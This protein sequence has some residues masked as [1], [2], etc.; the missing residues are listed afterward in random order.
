MESYEKLGAFYL[1]REYDLGA[2]KIGPGQILY[3]SKDLCTHA[4]LVGMTGSGKT[5]LGISLLEEA[6]IDNIPVIAIDPKGDLTNLLLTF[7]DLSPQDFLPWINPQEA[8]AAGRTQAQYAADQAKIWAKG[9]ADW[10][11]GPERIARLKAAAEMTVYTPGSSA[12]VPVNVLRSFSPPPQAVR[13][14]LDLWR[15]R[16]KTTASSLLALL[17]LES[18]PLTS[19]EHILLSN[20]L[21][22]FWSAGRSLDLAGLIQSIQAPPL[23]RIGVM[24]LDSFFPAQD[25]FALAMRLNGLLAAPGFEAWLE[26]PTLD[27][28]QLLQTKDGRPRASIFTISHLGDAER[29]FFVSMLFNEALGWM[30]SQPGTTS[31]RALI[32]MDEVFGFFPPVKNPPSKEPLL[33]LLKQARA[34]GLGVVLSTQNPVDLDYKGLSNAGTWFVGRLQAE[35]DKERLLAG[36]EG[37]SAGP[38]FDRARLDKIISGLGKRVF[39]M[40][41]VHDDQPRVFHTRWAL[42]YLRGP[43]TREQIKTLKE[44]SGAPVAVQP[45]Q[46]PPPGLPPLGQTPAPGLPATSPALDKAP[47]PAPAA[48]AGPPP[49]SRPVLP[50][51]LRALY[52]PAS[53]AGAD[54][55]YYPAVMGCLEVNYTSTKYGLGLSKPLVLASQLEDGPIPLDWDQV[56]DLAMDPGNLLEEPMS[57]V[58]HA[59]LP[60]LAGQSKAYKQWRTDLLRWVRHNR[61][62]VLLHSKDFDLTSQPEEDEGSF[63]ARLA[64]VAREQ[65]DLSVEKL[66]NKYAT[67]F[68]TLENRLMRAQQAVARESEQAKAKKIETAIS[69]GSAI[70]G[71]F[72]G[73]KAISANSAYRVGTAMKTAGRTRKEMM[74]VGRAKETMEAVQAE[75]AELE[76]RVQEEVAGMEG[77]FDPTRPGVGG[78]PHPGQVHRHRGAALRPGLAALSPGRDRPPDP[79]LGVGAPVR[80]DLNDRNGGGACSRLF[81]W[82][83]GGP[84]ALPCPLLGTDLTGRYRP[85][86][87]RA[88]T[89][90]RAFRRAADRPLYQ[91]ADNGADPTAQNGLLDPGLQV[92]QT[93]D[94][95]W[96]VVLKRIGKGRGC[97]HPFVLPV[98]HGLGQH[99]RLAALLAV[100]GQGVDPQGFFEV[101]AARGIG[102][103]IDVAQGTHGSLLSRP[104][105]W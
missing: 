5:G 105:L 99:V 75:M 69:F 51:D 38:G 13:D 50:P 20:I 10:D 61:P 16:I 97:L 26:G 77:R 66:R 101:L 35:R 79:G 95:G 25:R 44:T 21:E 33:T 39:L 1:G 59:E 7:P 67:R 65:R 46:P 73:R 19:R 54:L 71:A 32:Y 11:Q 55:V 49:S 72:L 37:V 90:P 6:L 83:K 93:I 60:P 89:L 15:E 42:S 94:L 103:E 48:P 62:L 102:S 63:R 92:A 45:V 86:R 57:G 43:L 29:M 104:A 23:T 9:L 4:V 30:R 81:F 70:L 27:F 36:L 17:G 3:D 56:L 85:G 24:D 14:D 40:H 58:K 84:E 91:L 8:V 87:Y 18:D 52:L 96:A 78:G 28:N 31:L 41:N 98:H 100:L 88:R 53:G 80:P 12:G 22:Q 68:N 76:T 74:D 64:Q 2:G 47:V 82:S 34:F